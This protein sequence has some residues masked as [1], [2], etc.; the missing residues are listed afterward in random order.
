MRN[1]IERLIYNKME[2]KDFGES[3]CNETKLKVLRWTI[4]QLKQ[5]GVMQAE[6]SDGAEGAAVADGAAGQSGSVSGSIISRCK[7]CGTIMQWPVSTTICD[8]CAEAPPEGAL[9]R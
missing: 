6:A 9:P 1:T 5:H 2:S 3:M 8:R 7:D 4:Q